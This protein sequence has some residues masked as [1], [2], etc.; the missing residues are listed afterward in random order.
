MI[1]RR[2]KEDIMD[3]EQLYAAIGGN[4]QEARSRLMSDKII[5]KFVIKFLSD[6]SYEQ[7][8]QAWE[9]KD[10]DAIFKSAHTMKGVCSNLALTDIYDV[11]NV[12]TESYRPGKSNERNDSEIEEKFALLKERY[13]NAVKCIKDF[14]AGQ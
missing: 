8:A 1:N 7:L 2:I 10:E 12:I 11:V 13:E 6:P 9:N 5:A 3:T 14:E 4:Y